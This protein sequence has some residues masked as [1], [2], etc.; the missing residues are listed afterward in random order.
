MARPQPSS[1]QPA[2]DS[3]RVSP[4][5]PTE[6]RETPL[7]QGLGQFLKRYWWLGLSGF[8]ALLAALAVGSAVNLLRLP[9]LPNCRAIFWPTASAAT[10]LQC[11]EAYAA[12]GSVDGYL[13][14]INLIQSLPQDHPL[15]PQISQH[16]ETWSRRILDLAE[17][18]FQAG[19]MAAAIAVARRIPI[20]TAGALMVTKRVGQWQQIWKEGETIEQGVDSLLAQ[21]KF[22]EAFTQATQLLDLDNTYWKTTRYNQLIEKITAARA[23]LDKL[24]KAKRLGS[25]RTLAALQEALALAQ[26]IDQKSPVYGEAQRVIQELSQDLLAMARSA[27]EA[28]NGLAARQ[29]LDAIPPQANLSEPIADLNLILDASQLAWQANVAGLEGA[30]ARLQTLG[31][32]RPLYGYA[33]NLIGQWQSET[34]QRAHLDWAHQLALRGTAGDLRRAIA[35]AE[36]VSSDTAVWSE[37]KAAID[38]WRQ[39]IQTA[40]DTPLLTQAQQQA[41]AGNLT[42]AVT[43]LTRIGPDRSLYSQAQTLKERWRSDLERKEDGPRLT[44]AQQL[45]MAGRLAE[46]IALASGIAPGRSLYD[47]AQANIAIWRGQQGDAPALQSAYQ[48]AQSGTVTGLVEAIKIAQ[49]LSSSGGDAGQA[50]QA[51]SAWSFDLLRLADQEALLNRARAITIVSQIPAQSQ[52]YAEAQLRLRQWQTP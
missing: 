11:A 23:D 22:Q 19:Q 20:Q 21:L 48:M 35:E 45:A 51:I 25:Q 27:L 36:K 5:A 12:Q 34:K 24:G 38:G 44:Q 42:G 32:D 4:R 50:N 37:A 43:T 14:A 33:Q 49:Q 3:R 46:A 10:R 31:N 40:E 15:H 9:N 16:I 29:M 8:L 52:A 39:Q 1:S 6:G 17:Q 26:T 7:S 13:N 41:A 18:S 47:Q 28:K 30:I 2:S